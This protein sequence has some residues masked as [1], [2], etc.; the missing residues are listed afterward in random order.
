MYLHSS[1]LKLF[2]LRLLRYLA[3]SI[4]VNTFKLNTFQHSLLVCFS[5]NSFYAV[6]LAGPYPALA[7]HE[8]HEC[9]PHIMKKPH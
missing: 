6:R 5:V 8:S 9:K 7:P 2:T 3:G 1:T 4:D